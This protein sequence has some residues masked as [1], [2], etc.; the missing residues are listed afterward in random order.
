MRGLMTAAVSAGA[1]LVKVAGSMWSSMQHAALRIGIEPG[2][3]VGGVGSVGGG[4]G[5]GPLPRRKPGE[6][7]P[8]DSAG[9][10]H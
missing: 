8:G 3:G 5:Y 2:G 4:V 1:E 10:L 9:P 7:F 6:L